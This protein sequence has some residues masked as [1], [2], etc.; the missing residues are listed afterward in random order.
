MKSIDYFRKSFILKDKM[1]AEY[2]FLYFGLKSMITYISNAN[3]MQFLLSNIQIKINFQAYSVNRNSFQNKIIWCNN[4]QCFEEKQKVTWAKFAT[5]NALVLH[6]SNCNYMENIPIKTISP[7]SRSTTPF[8]DKGTIESWQQLLDT[9]FYYEGL[10]ASPL[11]GPLSIVPTSYIAIK[12]YRN[13]VN[14]K[15]KPLRKNS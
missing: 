7:G 2:S 4:I 14:A 6:R 11:A 1:G 10:V 8:L 5:V 15:I 13:V 12:R 9:Q 3:K